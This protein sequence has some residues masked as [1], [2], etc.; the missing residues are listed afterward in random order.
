MIG[1]SISCAQALTLS[2]G[3]RWYGRYGN[4]PCPICQPDARPGQNALTLADGA[5]GLLAHCKKTGCPFR[6]VLAAL[7]IVPGTYLVPEPSITA[8]REAEP[9]FVAARVRRHT[10]L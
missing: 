9:S 3:G 5:K 8:Q 10:G 7:G 1:P 4:L 6:D 2:R